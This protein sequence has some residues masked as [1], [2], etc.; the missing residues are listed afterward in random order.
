[1]HAFQLNIR[2]VLLHRKKEKKILKQHIRKIFNQG[3]FHFSLC[4]LGVKVKRILR[5]L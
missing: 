3:L 4:G 2:Y 1:M 5:K